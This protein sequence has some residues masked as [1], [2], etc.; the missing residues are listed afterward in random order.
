MQVGTSVEHCVEELVGDPHVARGRHPFVAGD[1]RV[2]EGG[3]AS[4][5]GRG[6]GEHDRGRV[7]VPGHRAIPSGNAN[8]RDGSGTRN[9]GT[10]REQVLDGSQCERARWCS[11]GSPRRP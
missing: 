2:G 3:E 11:W 10:L 8:E 5:L 1:D 4:A 9:V 6:D 7:R